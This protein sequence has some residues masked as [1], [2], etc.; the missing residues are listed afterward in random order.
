LQK[1]L[2]KEAKDEYEEKAAD[3]KNPQGYIVSV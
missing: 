3:P 1:K 2:D